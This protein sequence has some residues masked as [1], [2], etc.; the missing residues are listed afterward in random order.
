MPCWVEK[1]K[2]E[3]EKQVEYDVKVVNVESSQCKLMSSVNLAQ[4]L[5]STAALKKK[6][7]LEY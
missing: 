6:A 3:S 2:R 5:V 1:G 7:V 4:T